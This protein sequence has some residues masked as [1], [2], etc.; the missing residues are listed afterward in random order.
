MA[1]TQ[2]PWSILF[3]FKPHH[4]PHSFSL[5]TQSGGPI[6][7]PTNTMQNTWVEQQ[8][9]SH[10]WLLESGEL[11][12]QTAPLVKCSCESNPLKYPGLVVHTRDPRVS[13]GRGREGQRGRDG[14]REVE[15]GSEGQREAKRVRETGRSLQLIGYST[16]L[17]RKILKVFNAGEPPSQ[18]P[19]ASICMHTYVHVHSTTH[20]HAHICVHTQCEPSIPSQSP[21]QKMPSPSSCSLYTSYSLLLP[22]G[23]A[24][25][26]P[27]WSLRHISLS[28]L[29]LDVGPEQGQ[30]RVYTKAFLSPVRRAGK[31]TFTRWLDS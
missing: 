25:P 26:Q 20:E 11:S 13:E 8:G 24:A 22:W 18:V 12:W 6:S 23:G 31:R 9:W 21:H 17:L 5:L 3:S 7:P 16:Y 10:T 28:G 19:L 27:S 15:R 30:F 2:H 4:L 29:F 1:Q 14:Q